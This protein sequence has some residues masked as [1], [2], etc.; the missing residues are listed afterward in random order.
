MWL[1][2]RSCWLRMRLT[3]VLRTLSWITQ[4]LVGAVD[5]LHALRTSNFFCCKTFNQA[6]WMVV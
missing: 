2:L 5:Q 1:R 3:V 6:I 4:Q